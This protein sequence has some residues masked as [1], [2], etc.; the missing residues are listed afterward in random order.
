MVVYHKIL[1][2]KSIEHHRGK[3]FPESWYTFIID[4]NAEGY[5]SGKLLFKFKK[6]KIDETLNDL[7]IQ[8]FLKESKKKH[9]NRGTAAG[10]PRGEKNARHLTVTGQNEGNYV[11]S[12][13]SGYFDRPL[14]EHRGTLGTIVACRTTAFTINN[15]QLWQKGLPFIKKVS[16][17]YKKYSNTEW[18]IQKREFGKI[19]SSVKIPG[20]VFTTITSNYNWQTACHKD[21]GDFSKGLGNLVVTGNG[22]TGGYL[23]F[24]QFKILIKI[25]PGDIL[26]MDS[27]EWHCNTPIKI[28]NSSGFRLSFVMYIRE[29]M[30]KCKSPKNIN[31]NKYFI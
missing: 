7:A 13:I 3:N 15:Q 17:L 26:F 11:S 21:Q 2:D 6:N 31:G 10:I 18:S 5:H 12:N 24:P 4:S 30:S 1:S 8:T 25:K 16:S 22:F 28:V 29:D 27:H 19:N 14:R 23:G 9:S 20:T